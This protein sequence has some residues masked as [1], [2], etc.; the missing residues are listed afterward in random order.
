MEF[1]YITKEN[2]PCWYELSWQ[3]KEP[4]IILRIHKDFI[5]NL[6]FKIEELPIVKF[7]REDFDFNEFSTDFEGDIGFDKVFKRIGEKNRFIEFLIKIPEVKRE[8]NKKCS[9]CNGSGKDEDLEQDCFF[10][11]GTGK[12]YIMDWYPAQVISASFSVLTT[13][14]SFHCETDTS[15]TT[16]Q[17]LTVETMTREGMHG[18]SLNGEISI[19]LCEWL[20][21]FKD[22]AEI[23]EAVQSMITAYRRMFG[24]RDYQIFDFRFYVRDKG[25]F[26]ANCP[27]DACGMHPSDWYFEKGKGYKFSCHNVDTPM[28]QITLL[29]SLA[30]LYD[31]ARKNIKT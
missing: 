11:E 6:D 1:R 12:D 2:M 31:K 16:S 19:P 4:A 14:L 22:Y 20:S 27:G 9:H 8:T 3:E 17:L 18:G 5:K 15:A 30:A 7:L 26:I 28:Q 21:S 13:L 25:R 23:P 29:A 24:L 10:C